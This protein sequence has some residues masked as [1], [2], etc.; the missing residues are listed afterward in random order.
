MIFREHATTG[1]ECRDVRPVLSLAAAR[2]VSVGEL[3]NVMQQFPQVMINVEVADKGRLDEAE[4]VWEAVRAREAQLDGTGR[5]LV[6][7]SGTEPLVR[8]MV[9]A[10]TEQ[11]ARSAEAVYAE[12][13][14]EALG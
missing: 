6:C 5:V 10:E 7:A 13:V 3:A 11:L 4:E 9:E 1:D 8:V 12:R 2:D 14:A